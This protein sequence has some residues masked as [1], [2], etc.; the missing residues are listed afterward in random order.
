MQIKYLFSNIKYQALLIAL[1]GWIA[2]PATFFLAEILTSYFY[3]SENVAS[4]YSHAL[5]IFAYLCWSFGFFSS[6]YCLVKRLK[7]AQS[8]VAFIISAVPI[9]ITIYVAVI[10]Q[11]W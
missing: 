9:I 11:W 10:F 3:I 4:N 1:V 7:I 5:S 6:L 8:I 2:A